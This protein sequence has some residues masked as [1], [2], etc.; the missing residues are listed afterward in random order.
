MWCM[1]VECAG[2]VLKTLKFYEN[3]SKTFKITSK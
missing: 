2:D 3:K 1:L